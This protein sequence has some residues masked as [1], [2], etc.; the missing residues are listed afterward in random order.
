M[1]NKEQALIAIV[2]GGYIE[3]RTVYCGIPSEW[4]ILGDS[5]DWENADNNFQYR[6]AVHTETIS[7]YVSLNDDWPIHIDPKSK[8]RNLQ[9]TFED[10]LIVSARAIPC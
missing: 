8:K 4:E 6:K 9:L 7:V 5:F 3:Y 2:R 1:L 10:G